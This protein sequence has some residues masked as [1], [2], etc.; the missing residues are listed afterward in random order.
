MEVK[1][2]TTGQMVTVPMRRDLPGYNVTRARK[3]PRMRWS[4]P[5]DIQWESECI[6]KFLGQSCAC[7]DGP[8]SGPDKENENKEQKQNLR[9]RGYDTLLVDSAPAGNIKKDGKFEMTSTTTT[10]DYNYKVPGDDIGPV[11]ASMA[12]SDVNSGRDVAQR[13]S[14]QGFDTAGS[15]PIS[16]LSKSPVLR[17]RNRRRRQLISTTDM[18]VPQS[19]KHLPDSGVRL[20]AFDVI[21]SQI[22]MTGNLA[23]SSPQEMSENPAEDQSLLADIVE[24]E[25]VEKA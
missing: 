18:L 3:S 14:F 15:L 13:L 11:A 24:E 8:K 4:L 20:T 19:G 1:D 21:Q 12:K 7:C 2:P 25:N 23:E 9:P 5:V 22:N 17:Q 6:I 10:I 16:S